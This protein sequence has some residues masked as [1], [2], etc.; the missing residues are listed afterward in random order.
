MGNC[1]CSHDKSV[2]DIKDLIVVPTCSLGEYVHMHHL[3]M[4]PSLS[5]MQLLTSALLK[6]FII[7]SAHMLTQKK[8][9]L[10]QEI[11]GD[12]WPFCMAG[13]GAKQLGTVF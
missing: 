4:F 3:H 7:I 12:I 10:F 5:K 2:K 6:F 13:L 1:S 9:A 11:G 8:K